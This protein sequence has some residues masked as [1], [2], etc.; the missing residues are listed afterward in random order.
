MSC[1]IATS[2]SSNTTSAPSPSSSPTRRQST[3]RRLEWS[4]VPVWWLRSADTSSATASSIASRISA[5]EAAAAGERSRSVASWVSAVMKKAYCPVTGLP[6]I[7]G[8]AAPLRIRPPR[9]FGARCR[10]TT[11][12]YTRARLLTGCWKPDNPCPTEARHAARSSASRRAPR[13]VLDRRRARS[14]STIPAAPA[15]PTRMPPRSSARPAPRRRTASP[16]PRPSRS[17][18]A[19]A[20]VLGPGAHAPLGRRADRPRRLA[21]PRGPRQA[22]LSRA[23]LGRRRR[24]LQRRGWTPPGNQVPSVRGAGLGSPSVAAMS[25]CPSC[26]SC[27]LQPLRSRPGKGGEMLVELRCPE[28]FMWMQECCTRAELAELTSARRRGASCW[29]RPTSVRSRS[30][31]RRSPSAWV[32]RSRSIWSMPT[33]LLPARRRDAVRLGS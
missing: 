5:P 31:W 32:R 3:A 18:A 33:I 14:G 8:A 9:P 25:L 28:C 4:A 27:L 7:P 29:S 16:S 6:R 22:Q 21:R 17:R 15:A 11:G 20:R 24:D 26:G 19:A 23:R 1:R 13:G 2:S 12:R 30:R 10:R